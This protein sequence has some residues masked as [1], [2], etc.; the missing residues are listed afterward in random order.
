MLYEVQVFFG[1]G[2]ALT[3]HRMSLG[4]PLSWEVEMAMI[5]AFALHARALLD[6]FTKETGRGD[7]ALAAEFFEPDEWAKLRPMPG[8]WAHQIKRKRL[9]RVGKQIAH[10]TYYK[11]VRAWPVVQIAGD[12]GRVLSVFVKHVPADHVADDFKAAAWRRSRSSRGSPRGMDV[13]R[14]FGRERLPHGAA[15][16]RAVVGRGGRARQP[17]S[18]LATD[19][20]TARG[21]ARAP[22]RVRS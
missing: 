11:D 5:E 19:A 16:D 17:G 9:D 3:R 20:S 7:D 6:F 15:H 21:R 22:R 18:H 4:R 13:A 2:R 1:I 14:R 12:L 10:L 8:E